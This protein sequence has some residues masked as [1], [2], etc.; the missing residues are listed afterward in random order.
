MGIYK[1]NKRPRW[2]ARDEQKSELKIGR[3]QLEF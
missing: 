2:V 3:Q 1:G